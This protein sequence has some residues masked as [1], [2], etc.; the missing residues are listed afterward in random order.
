MTVSAE[1]IHAQNLPHTTAEYPPR[2]GRHLFRHRRRDF[3]NA[4]LVADSDWPWL[5]HSSFTGIVPS[6]AGGGKQFCY[7]WGA[8]VLPAPAQATSTTTAGNAQLVRTFP[9]NHG[10]RII[11]L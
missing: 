5:F 9:Q 10:Y 4:H 2:F 11:I 8:G 7:G 3:Q 1:A 6:A